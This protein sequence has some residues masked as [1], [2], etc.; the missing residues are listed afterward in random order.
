MKDFTIRERLELSLA[1]EQRRQIIED[2][3]NTWDFSSE[4]GKK[5]KEDFIEEIKIIDELKE[6]IV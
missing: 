1:L 5:V 3:L 4:T 6:K 2:Y